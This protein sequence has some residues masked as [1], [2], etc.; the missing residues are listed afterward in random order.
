MPQGFVSLLGEDE[1]Q[2]SRMGCKT[3]LFFSLVQTGFPRE[4]A[5]LLTRA[6]QPGLV[7]PSCGD[8]AQRYHRASLLLLRQVCGVGEQTPPLWIVPNDKA[9][10]LSLSLARSL[11]LSLALSLSLSLALSLALSRRDIHGLRQLRLPVGPTVRS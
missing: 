11:S 3:L 9:L 6:T 2:F 1:W 4:L 7:S 5:K 10:S 8:Q